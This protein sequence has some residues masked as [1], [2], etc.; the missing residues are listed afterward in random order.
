MAG[1]FLTGVLADTFNQ[2]GQKSH[3]CEQRG[4]GR[5]ALGTETHRIGDAEIELFEVGS[6]EPLL[7]LHSAQG[8]DPAHP[9]VTRLAA[10]RRVIAPSHPGFGRSSLPEWVDA[11][12]D[13]AHIYLE[14]L[15]RLELD[16]VDVLG[17]SI[18]GWIA[19]D[20]AS[21]VPERLRRLVLVGPVGVK[22][23]P[24]DRLDVPDIFAIPAEQVQRLMF[25]DPAKARVDFTALDDEA[26]TIVARNRETLAML[27]WEPYMHSAKL[28]HRLHRVSLPTLFIRGAS[29]GLVS[30]EYL[31]RYAA[32]IPGARIT[33]I[34]D[35]GHA[36][37]IEQPDA[38]VREVEAFLATQQGDRS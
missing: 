8:F 33:T 35:A 31:E 15:D 34:A 30:A 9:F 18:G 7:F 12:D 13:I 28:R 1:D 4:H 16:R 20:L 24:V 25:H 23:G 22:T 21:K 14:L 5:S 11:V 27:V 29:D 36:P 37:Q 2:D 19:A 38:F 17:C 32:L 6:G 10:T 3:P 26:M